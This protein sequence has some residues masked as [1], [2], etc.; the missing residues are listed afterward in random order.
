MQAACRATWTAYADA[1]EAKY[2]VK[3]VRNATVNAQVKQIV[4]RI[5]AVD[6]PHVCAWFPTHP[7]AFYVAKGH[8]M[9]V[10]LADA[11]KLRTEWA[12]GSAMTQTRARQADRA[13]A[14]A[15]IVGEILNERRASA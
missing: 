14:T 5:G 1:Y 10:L 3:P 9:G 6:A 11:E 13:G 8:A 4:Q 12:T 2:G 15:G 7:G